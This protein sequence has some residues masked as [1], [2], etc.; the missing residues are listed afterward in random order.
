MVVGRQAGGGRGRRADLWFAAGAG[1]L[2]VVL[3]VAFALIATTTKSEKPDLFGGIHFLPYHDFDVTNG[4]VAFSAVDGGP[5]GRIGQVP[6]LMAQEGNNQQWVDPYNTDEGTYLVDRKT[7]N[8]SLLLPTLTT[9]NEV[10]TRLAGVGADGA[11][12]LGFAS[13]AGLYVVRRAASADA[14][15]YA[16]DVHL[17]TA[18][19]VTTGTE[20]GASELPGA[21]PVATLVE[22]AAVLAGDPRVA[23]LGAAGRFTDS[24]AAVASGDHLYLVVDSGGGRLLKVSEPSAETLATYDPGAITED[25][26]APPPPRLDVDELGSLGSGTVLTRLPGGGGVAT[27]DPASGEV[28]F[29]SSN[30][31]TG[32]YGVSGLRG[33]ATVL[34][35]DGGD[36]AGF[37]VRQSEWRL[38]TVSRS[39]AVRST[40]L[41]TFGAEDLAPGAVV[42]NTVFSASRADGTILAADVN[43]GDA[44]AVAADGRYPVD[45]ELDIAGGTL[46]SA[47]YRAVS[48]ERLG[49]RVVV[50]VPA[51]SRAVLLAS[52]G[53]L[54]QE[55]EK[56][57]ARPFDPNT[58]IDPNRR[59]DAQEDEPQPEDE[60]D[61][62]NEP[63]LV[64]TPTIEREGDSTLKCEDEESQTP[65]PAVLLPQ[66]GALAPRSITP[67]WR[68]DLLSAAECLA[69]FRLIIDGEPQDL[70]RP[71]ALSA[72]ITGL[73]PDTEY[74][75]VVISFIGDRQARSNTALYR[76]GPT[77]PDAPTNLRFVDDGS[78]WTIAWDACTTRSQCDDP[79]QRFE[80]TWGDTSQIG[81]GRASVGAQ[82]ARTVTVPITNENV[83][84][85][86]C[87]EV[88]SYGGANTRSDPAELCGKRY[89]APSGVGA[90]LLTSVE[91]Q[92]FTF[93]LV[94]RLSE[95]GR[96]NFPTYFGTREFVEVAVDVPGDYA[97][98]TIWR[99]GGSNDEIRMSGLTANRP[100]VNFTAEFSH[101]NHPGADR[102]TLDVRADPLACGKINVAITGTTYSANIAGFGPGWPVTFTGSVALE[103][104]QRGCPQNALQSLRVF[105]PQNCRQAPPTPLTLDCTTATKTVNQAGQSAYGYTFEPVA[106]DG[107]SFS[108]LQFTNTPTLTAPTG[109]RG[110]E[111]SVVS[112]TRVGSTPNYDVTLANAFAASG[113]SPDI[114]GCTRTGALTFRCS[115]I[116]YDLAG[117]GNFRTFT[118]VPAPSQP[119]GPFSDSSTAPKCVAGFTNTATVQYNAGACTLALFRQYDSSDPNNTTTTTIVGGEKNICTWYTPEVNWGTVDEQ[120]PATADPPYDEIRYGGDR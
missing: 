113:S 1:A 8:V 115:S 41:P 68:Y 66:S 31:Q 116:R 69:S 46:T 104:T 7:G 107:Y 112:V 110:S 77:G 84:R 76:T 10:P 24:L 2:V 43:G 9:A 85:E 21:L 35:V 94:V 52:D 114:L 12:V 50:N 111:L 26:A 74:E 3:F 80:V 19:S 33:A 79:A 109:V 82:Q 37:L 54:I 27:A 11:T 30:G 96:R 13:D 93:E 18:S 32:R 105:A 4:P 78:A 87:F 39:G 56:G 49:T 90:V 101:P 23:G 57:R 17:L 44:V 48:V 100:F 119:L 70:A 62:N 51:A 89:R 22:D 38:V 92:G 98:S 55:L 67:R 20:V 45:A 75:V 102:V 5:V 16:G 15:G 36:D 88:T 86:L 47:D 59:G 118:L 103:G 117:E 71:N 60:D 42:G 65:R 120:C 28:T 40:A 91:R 61:P 25:G 108:G 14:G 34:P 64:E 95:E 83:G 73:S 72:T 106:A 6:V 99:P 29:W 63:T 53:S 97:T 58:L 81:S